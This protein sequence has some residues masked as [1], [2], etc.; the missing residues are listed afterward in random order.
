MRK[1]KSN[2]KKVKFQTGK[3]Q[4][5]K[6][7]EEGKFT[8]LAAHLASLPSQIVTHI[9]DD[10][11]TMLDLFQEILD[12]ETPLSSF[13][14]KLTLSSGEE[15]E[16]TP[17]CLLGYKNPCTGSNR[18]KDLDEF[19]TV[20]SEF[21]ELLAKYK[22]DGT[23][24]LK[25][26]AELE[27]SHRKTL[28]Q[29]KQVKSLVDLSFNLVVSELAKL[30]STKPEANLSNQKEQLA[31][32]I[33]YELA[34]TTFK[35]RE[36]KLLC[37]GSLDDFK[38]FFHKV[39][40]DNEVSFAGAIAI[41]QIN[42]DEQA[43]RTSVKALLTDLVSKM[44]FDAWQK[45]SEDN[46]LRSINREIAIRYEKRVQAA[47]QEATANAITQGAG[48]GEDT[49]V[50]QLLD[51]QFKAYTKKFESQLRAKYSADPKSQGSNARNNGRNSSKQ[52]K[53]SHSNSPQSSK[54]KK[55]APKTQTQ[56]N[57]N[58]NQTPKTQ[59]KQSRKRKAGN[60]DHGG[61]ASGGSKKRSRKR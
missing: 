60:G 42:A 46:I 6:L 59:Q 19:K 23:N 12:R 54:K 52:A 31:W 1:S 49:T 40:A 35:D 13:G 57:G 18:T 15:V 58:Q 44:S 45:R 2:D 38:T 48:V 34:I 24:L 11:N 61:A 9:V 8:D 16:Y 21:D 7:E 33:A 22:K 47:S 39:R 10:A 37:F 29:T 30:K 27:V 28:L 43:V 3:D 56:Q 36:L 32:S 41:S 50:K 20:V 55:Q 25:R 53:R 14:T 17:G 51:K 4:A 5:E 26:L